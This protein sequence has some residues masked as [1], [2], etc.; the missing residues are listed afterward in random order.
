M[1]KYVIKETT[2]QSLY[3]SLVMNSKRMNKGNENLKKTEP[4]FG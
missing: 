4:S 3:A 2:K 1:E